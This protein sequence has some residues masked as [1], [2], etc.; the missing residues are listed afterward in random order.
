MPY[1]RTCSTCGSRSQAGFCHCANVM[2]SIH[3]KPTIVRLRCVVGAYLPSKTAHQTL[4]P[5]R[6][7]MR[8][9]VMLTHSKERYFTGAEAPSYA[10]QLK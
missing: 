2:I 9:R 6:I 10:K 3:D 8:D 7:F 5:T 4:F 1:F